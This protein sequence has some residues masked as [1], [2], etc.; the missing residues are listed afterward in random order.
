MY[1]ALYTH[2]P[3]DVEVVVHAD[4]PTLNRAVADLLAAGEVLDVLSTHSK[5]APSQAHWLRP[6]DDLIDTSALPPRAVGL[7]RW[8]GAQYCVPRNTDVRI[9]WW[10]TD[11]L[12]TAPATWDDVLTSPAVFGFTGRESGLFGLYFELVVGAGGDPASA[13]YGNGPETQWAAA[14]I[15]ALADRVPADVTAWHYDDVGYALASGAVDLAAAWPGATDMLLASPTG[16]HLAPARYPAGRAAWVS[17]S[18]CHAWAIPTSS[19]RPE[20]AAEVIAQLLAVG[21]AVHPVLHP[22]LDET[23]EQAMITYP[24]HA[25]FPEIEDAG[26]RALGDMI[27]GRRTPHEAVAAIHR[28]S[29]EVLDAI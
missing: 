4:H 17:Y 16:A 20:R 12:P 9:L 8:D 28:R 13:V 3:T 1:D 26:W 24:P 15:A 2:L 10:R 7:C 18:G 23:I 22:V 5:Y 14:T 21:D 6:L 19:T 27:L 25:R 11:R 29:M